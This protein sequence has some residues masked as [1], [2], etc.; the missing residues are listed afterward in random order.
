VNVEEDVQSLQRSEGIERE[1]SRRF[2]HCHT[3]RRVDAEVAMNLPYRFRNTVRAFVTRTVRTRLWRHPV[4]CE[5]DPAGTRRA[6][7]RSVGW[8]VRP[9]AIDSQPDAS[10]GLRRTHVPGP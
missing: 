6:G 4:T 9:G 8:R 2:L 5:D 3:R 10:R 1:K 7:K